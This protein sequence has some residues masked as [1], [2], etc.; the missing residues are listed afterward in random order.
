MAAVSRGTK[1]EFAREAGEE[2]FQPRTK[3]VISQQWENSW[4]GSGFL[5]ENPSIW[6]PAPSLYERHITIDILLSSK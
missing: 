5:G 3:F 2:Y 4:G 6:I 1:S